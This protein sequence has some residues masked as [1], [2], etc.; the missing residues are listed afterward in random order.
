MA[1]VWILIKKDI[2]P[3]GGSRGKK[4]GKYST[5]WGGE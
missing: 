4:G 2:I 1:P 3:E 5:G